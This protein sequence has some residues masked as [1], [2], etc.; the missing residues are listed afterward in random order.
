MLRASFPAL[1][2]VTV[3]LTVHERPAEKIGEIGSSFDD[4]A[5]KPYLESLCHNLVRNL[6]ARRCR[7]P[8]MPSLSI[9]K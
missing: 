5:S 8:P 4:E 3:N 7:K 1:S 2:D 9:L 6:V